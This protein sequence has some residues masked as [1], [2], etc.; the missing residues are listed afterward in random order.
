MLY[1]PHT[2]NHRIRH[3][4]RIPSASFS[5]PGSI[6]IV[7]QPN[8][9]LILTLTLIVNPNPKFNPNPNPYP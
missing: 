9:N 8:G 4:H 6:E 1:Q 7:N 5:Q 2:V 3:G